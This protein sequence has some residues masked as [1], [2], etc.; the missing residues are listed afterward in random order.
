MHDTV[1]AVLRDPAFRRSLS[2]SLGERAL[3]WLMEGFARLREMLGQVPSSRTLALGFV[4]L[5]VLLA[6]ARIVIVA[7]A[8]SDHDA[9][10]PAT[11][12]G[13]SAEDPWALAQRLADAGRHE[14]AAHALY[15]AVLLSLSRA[16]RF[17]L[18]PSRTSGDYARELRRRGASSLMPFRAFVRRF[19]YAVYG[20]GGCGPADLAELRELASSFA[21][22]AHAA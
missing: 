12:G 9:E 16:E 22:R 7:Q 13:A 8:R 19:D 11:R 17:R 21:P 2:R 6:V 15:R 5:L 4:V 18:D 1:T 14:E 3:L 20:H 10:S